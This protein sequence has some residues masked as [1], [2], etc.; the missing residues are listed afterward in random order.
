MKKDRIEKKRVSLNDLF[1]CGNIVII[2]LLVGTLIMTISTVITLAIY[3]MV[4]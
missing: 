3:L 4:Y 1:S 2:T